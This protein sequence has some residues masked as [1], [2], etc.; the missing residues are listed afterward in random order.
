MDA[1]RIR[2]RTTE[3]LLVV[4]K[5]RS[6]KTTLV[7]RLTAGVGRLV[8][9]DFKHQQELPAASVVVW[10]APLPAGRVVVRFSPDPAHGSVSEQFDRVCYEVLRRGNT[11]LVVDDAMMVTRGQTAPHWYLQVLTL[12]ASRGVGCI[13][14]VQDPVHVHNALLS[15][16]EHRFIF[17]VNVRSHRQKLAGI[18]GDAIDPIAKSLDNFAF[19]YHHDGLRTPVR[20]EPLPV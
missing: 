19:A 4:G 8:W 7:A 10:P 6:G 12:G 5:T 17:R 20:C 16:S 3:R 9:C 2:I 13:S 15:Q 1:R 18:C 14:I 11:L